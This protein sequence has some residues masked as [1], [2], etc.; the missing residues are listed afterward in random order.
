MNN[1]L[2]LKSSKR[3]LLLPDFTPEVIEPNMVQLKNINHDGKAVFS[4]GYFYSGAA[5]LSPESRKIVV[6]LREMAGKCLGGGVLASRDLE[7]IG[8]G[9]A[10]EKPGQFFPKKK[11]FG[12]EDTPQSFLPSEWALFEY[13]LWL[14]P[15]YGEALLIKYDDV[16]AVT[17]T[18]TQGRDKHI[19][20][21]GNFGQQITEIHGQ[22]NATAM[23]NLLTI[24]GK[25]GVPTYA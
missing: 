7:W 15:P 5:F 19:Q 25:A 2:S 14:S 24:V 17:Q 1:P 12:Y 18:L 10:G 23:D 3:F 9:M 4:P 22:A 8:K 20:I 6:S 21:D 16:L 11:F 13:G